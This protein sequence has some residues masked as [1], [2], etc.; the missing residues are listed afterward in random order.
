M[1]NWT[2][3]YFVQK[4]KPWNLICYFLMLL[5]F[6]FNTYCF[7]LDC[8]YLRVAGIVPGLYHQFMDPLQFIIQGP[9]QSDNPGLDI[10]DKVTV[11]VTLTA[12]DFIQDQAIISFILI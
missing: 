2:P 7:K 10:H 9:V 5:I 4:A 6:I 12:V 3:V 1:C 11:W 8:K